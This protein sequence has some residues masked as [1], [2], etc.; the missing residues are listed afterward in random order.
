MH[1]RGQGVPQNYK[2]ALMWFH[3]AAKQGHARAQFYIG[4][5]ARPREK[6]KQLSGFKKR[7]TKAWK[8]Q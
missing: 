6:Y 3:K 4:V 1:K 5:K 8:A 7:L 2:E